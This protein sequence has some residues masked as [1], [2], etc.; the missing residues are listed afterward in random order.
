MSFLYELPLPIFLILCIILAAIM[1]YILFLIRKTKS[2][3]TKFAIVTIMA[4]PIIAI[5]IRIMEDNMIITKETDYEVTIT[6]SI[7]LV[8][9]FLMLFYAGFKNAKTEGQKNSMIIS[10]VLLIIAIVLVIIAII[11]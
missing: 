3:S 7:Y 8:I 10:S 6:F 2:L 4:G 9:L 1:A 11:L 5:I